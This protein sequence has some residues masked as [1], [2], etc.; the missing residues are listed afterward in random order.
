VTA[1][2]LGAHREGA[3]VNRVEDLEAKNERLR[4]ALV[5][6][7]EL[8]ESGNVAG[9]YYE[10]AMDLAMDALRDTERPTVR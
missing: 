5:I 10:E 1:I 7:Y 4:A 6:L 8:N 2:G 9:A 3:G